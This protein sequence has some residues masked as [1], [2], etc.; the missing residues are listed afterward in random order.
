LASLVILPLLY[1]ISG[2]IVSFSIGHGVLRRGT[3]GERTF[4][5]FLLFLFGL[6]ITP[7]VWLLIAVMILPFLILVLFR[8][9]QEKRNIDRES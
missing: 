5:V 8:I 1:L 9:Y 3:C 2:F 6:I 4:K 7:I